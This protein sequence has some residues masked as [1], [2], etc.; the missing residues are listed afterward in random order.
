MTDTT[1]IST[2]GPRAGSVAVSPWDD[3]TIWVSLTV[4]G[5]YLHTTMTQEQALQVADA[6][7]LAVTT[8][9]AA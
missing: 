4:P 5:A 1:F 9:E 6:L 3:G 2:T 7:R 8:S